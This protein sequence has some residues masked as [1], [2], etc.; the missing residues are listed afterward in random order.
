LAGG[1]A[2]FRMARIAEWPSTGTLLS[3]QHPLHDAVAVDQKVSQCRDHVQA[4]QYQQGHS[5]F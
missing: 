3:R 2:A 4:D 1:N 5:N